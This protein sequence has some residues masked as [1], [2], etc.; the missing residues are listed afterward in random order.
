MPHHFLIKD[1]AFQSG[2]GTAT[3]D[4]VLHARDHVRAQTRMR[5][6]AA[7]EELKR[8]EGLRA[9]G[10]KSFA[11]DIVLEAP[12]RF[13]REV[14]NAFETHAAALHP[15]LFRPRF[16]FSERIEPHIFAGYLDR[17]RARGSDGVV[18]KGPDVGPV[19]EAVDRLSSARIPVVTLVTDLTGTDRIAYT[20]IDNVAAGNTAAWL[21][22]KV[23]ASAN[24]T[25]LVTLSSD[26]FRSEED[27]VN[28]F[29]TALPKHAPSLNVLRVSEGFGRDETTGR[30]AAKALQQNPKICAVYSAGG[31]NRAVLQAFTNAGRAC[32]VFVAHDLDPDNRELVSKGLIDFVLHHDL[33]SDARAIYSLLSNPQRR[34]EEMLHSRM[35]VHTPFN[36]A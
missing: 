24:G 13:S 29:V 11:I 26:S 27:R 25:V 19:R 3:V 2:L 20:G 18:V 4:R 31:G 23:L 7:I 35:T 34:C 15:F 5:V 32:R 21:M 6:E 17:I 16:H 22:G 12:D 36:T 9:K 1:I 30:L 8:Q 28:A 14:R 10:G 33:A